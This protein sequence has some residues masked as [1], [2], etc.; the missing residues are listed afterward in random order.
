MEQYSIQGLLSSNLLQNIILIIS[1][2]LA[3]WVGGRQIWLADVVEL[4][5][6]P[7]SLSDG[8]IPVVL[9]QNVGT[10]LVYLDKYI[11]NGKSYITDGQVLPS[12][13]AQA[14]G[15]SYWI[16]LPTNGESHVSIEI[17][18]HDLDGRKWRSS[19]FADVENGVWKVK[20][21]PRTS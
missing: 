16:Q 11:F 6:S 14:S 20:T 5:G 12:T 13:Y 10:R 2:L 21:L 7:S 4:Y 8:K 18:Y 9:V 3:V 19:I 17:Y 1:L 15:G